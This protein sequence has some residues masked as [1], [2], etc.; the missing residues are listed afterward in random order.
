MDFY[1]FLASRTDRMKA[2]EVRE[3]VKYSRRK[4]LISFGG[5]LPNPTTLP[6]KEEIESAI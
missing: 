6:S 3:L 2:S 1:K 4:D 5:G